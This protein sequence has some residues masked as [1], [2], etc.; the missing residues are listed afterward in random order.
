MIRYSLSRKKEDFL[1]FRSIFGSWRGGG[2]FC[3]CFL[4]W[5]PCWKKKARYTAKLRYIGFFT[6]FQ[7]TYFQCVLLFLLS[8]KYPAALEKV[9]FQNCNQSREKHPPLL[10]ALTHP[11][12]A[13]GHQMLSLHRIRVPWTMPHPRTGASLSW[14]CFR[15]EADWLLCWKN[16]Y[17]LPVF[18]STV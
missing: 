8:L 17:R 18:G 11:L 13:W 6:L 2:S 12:Y 3:A 14:S 7:S 5:L 10:F 4:K 1:R 15:S 9:S 16:L